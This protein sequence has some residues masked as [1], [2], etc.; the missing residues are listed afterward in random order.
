MKTASLRGSL[1]GRTLD[2][3]MH[4]RGVVQVINFQVSAVPI[5]E[6]IILLRS[7][8]SLQVKGSCVI[9]WKCLVNLIS[10]LHVLDLLS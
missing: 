2:K 8:A 9:R 7:V 4:T 5:E 10:I 1:R 3:E 6:D